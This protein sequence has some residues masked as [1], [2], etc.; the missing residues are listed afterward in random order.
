RPSAG[1]LLVAAERRPGTIEV[2]SDGRRREH[3]L[4]LVGH[5]SVEAAV[6]DRESKRRPQA[7]RDRRAVREALVAGRRLERMGER[8]AEIEHGP[9]AALLRTAQADGRLV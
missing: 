8:V 3:C 5:R 1:R 7:E 4:D 9:L 2:D 6:L